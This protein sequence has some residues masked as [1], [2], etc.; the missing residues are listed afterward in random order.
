MINSSNFDQAAVKEAIKAEMHN[1]GYS[2]AELAKQMGRSEQTIRNEL[3]S[4]YTLTISLVKKFCDE[5]GCS[6]ESIIQG[7]PYR[8]TARIANIEDRLNG[9]ENQMKEVWDK[10]SKLK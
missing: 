10:L 2:Y 8:S 5:L 9:L 4:S 7:V 3:S 1:R 6:Y